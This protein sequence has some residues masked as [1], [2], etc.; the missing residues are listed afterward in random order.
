[1]N[2]LTNMLVSQTAQIS[3][4]IFGFFAKHKTQQGIFPVEEL[5]MVLCSDHRDD[6]I[7]HIKVKS[8]I[9]QMVGYF[10]ETGKINISLRDSLEWTFNTLLE[11]RRVP[12]QI[13]FM[14]AEEMEDTSDRR[15]DNQPLDEVGTLGDLVRMS[16][17]KNLWPY[18]VELD[19]LHVAMTLDKET[20]EILQGNRPQPATETD[21]GTGMYL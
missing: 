2:P 9:L 12:I 6:H 18:F 14:T 10:D 17:P 5:E 7:G 4:E 8:E 1:M 16:L 19:K 20:G 3:Q 11:N 21:H 13:A 15:L